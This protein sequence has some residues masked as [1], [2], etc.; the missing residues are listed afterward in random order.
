MG[1]Q[2]VAAHI[3]RI[4]VAQEPD[5]VAR[6][7]DLL[8]CE[9]DSTA[10]DNLADTTHRAAD[11]DFAGTVAVDVVDTTDFACLSLMPSLRIWH[12]QSGLRE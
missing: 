10:A 7:P 5:T 3:D 11:T 4:A 8:L 1:I 9:A 2:R 6:L 12:A